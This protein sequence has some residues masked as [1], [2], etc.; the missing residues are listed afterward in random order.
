MLVR[1][2]APFLLNSKAQKPL[3]IV[4]WAYNIVDI[5]GPQ[6]GCSGDRSFAPGAP[7]VVGQ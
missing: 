7:C 5:T 6:L 2:L 3:I 4:D 1:L